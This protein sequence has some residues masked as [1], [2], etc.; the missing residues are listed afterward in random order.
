MRSSPYLTTMSL[1]VPKMPLSSP[2]ILLQ[3]QGCH[4]KTIPWGGWGGESHTFQRLNL[5]SAPSSVDAKPSSCQCTILNVHPFPR[6]PW[7][8]FH[9]SSCHVSKTHCFSS[10]SSSSLDWFVFTVMYSRLSI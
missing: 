1:Q 2:S 8:R 10:S 7:I 9:S 4:G 3:T 6:F 5:F